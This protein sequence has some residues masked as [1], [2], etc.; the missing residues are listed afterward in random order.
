MR[1]EARGAPLHLQR[2]LQLSSPP[3]PDLLERRTTARVGLLQLRHRQPRPT[4]RRRDRGRG[5]RP[6]AAPAA[7]KRLPSGSQRLSVP[8]ETG[9]ER[10]LGRDLL[11]TVLALG[12]GLRLWLALT[13]DGGYW[14]DEIFQSVEPAH[15]LAFGYGSLPWEYVQGAR[16]W[17]LPGL[18]APL[19]IPCA[20]TGCTDPR[21]YLFP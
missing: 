11:V 5:R 21:I 16:T 10:R 18:I 15:R 13:D 7:S 6:G 19:M 4:R 9:T 3:R 20:L 12:L 17:V 8:P 2:R 1:L 14:P